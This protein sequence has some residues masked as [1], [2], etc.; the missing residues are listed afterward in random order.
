MEVGIAVLDI[1]LVGLQVT[2]H[3]QEGGLHNLQ[4]NGDATWMVGWIDGCKCAPR[5]M[6]VS[7]TTHS[8]ARHTL[9]AKRVGDTTGN[10]G[11]LDIWCEEGTTGL[12]G[13]QSRGWRCGCGMYQK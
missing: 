1:V 12:S 2:G 7:M 4:S 8:A 3:E 9:V 10:S 11:R 13:E 5:P 6:Y